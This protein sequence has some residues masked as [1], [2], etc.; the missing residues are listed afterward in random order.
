M[1]SL[2][3]LNLTSRSNEWRRSS[4]RMLLVNVDP[5]SLHVGDVGLT[6]NLRCTSAWAVRKHRT[7]A[8]WLRREETC[9]RSPE[10]LQK[11]GR[12]DWIRTSDPLRPRQVRYQA[13]LRPD[14]QFP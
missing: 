14:S 2:A 7:S 9:H 6:A 11:S 1:N 10:D 8:C 13:A 12:G 4:R 5:E 3:T